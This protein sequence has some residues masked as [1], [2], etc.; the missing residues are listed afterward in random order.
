[1]SRVR[2]WDLFSLAWRVLTPVS[3]VFCFVTYEVGRQ[4]GKALLGYS[5]NIT[6]ARVTFKEVMSCVRNNNN[7]KSSGELP[8]HVYAQFAVEA[9]A[10]TAVACLLQCNTFVNAVAVIAVYARTGS[11][12]Q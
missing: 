10:T 5:N 7:D 11:M 12:L 2:E 6:E 3:L 4:T 9:Q 1:M 8:V